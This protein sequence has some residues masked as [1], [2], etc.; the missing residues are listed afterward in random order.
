MHNTLFHFI[1]QSQACLDSCLV[2]IALGQRIQMK[3]L[4]IFLLLLMMCL[5]ITIVLLLIDPK[6]PIFP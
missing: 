3:Q 1:T 4:N 6:R 2:D 5:D